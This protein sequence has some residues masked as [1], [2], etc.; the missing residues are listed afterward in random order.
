MG[1]M[2][3]GNEEGEDYE[4][5]TYQSASIL[6]KQKVFLCTGCVGGSIRK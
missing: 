3:K 2:V 6:R 4:V 1:E 5:G